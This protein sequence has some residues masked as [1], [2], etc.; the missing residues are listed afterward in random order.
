MDLEKEITALAAETLAL[1]AILT[2]V[3]TQIGRLD[4]RI[5]DAIRA[6]FDDAASFVEDMA[7]KLGKSASSEH[8]VKALSIVEQLRAGSLDKP[9]QPRHGV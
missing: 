1:Q 6:G 4:P 3:F 2:S 8:T 9:D 5:A 7:I